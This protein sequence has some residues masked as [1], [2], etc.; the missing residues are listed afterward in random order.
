M[1]LSNSPERAWLSWTFKGLPG[2]GEAVALD[3]IGAQSWNVLDQDVMLPVAVIYNSAIEHNRRWMTAFT[4]AASV[5]LCP[6]GKTTMSPQLLEMQIADGAW[7]ITAATVAHVRTYRRFGIDRIIL[8]NQLIGKQNIAYIFDELSCNLGLDFYCLVDSIAA[9]EL[10][11]TAATHLQFGGRLQ[12]LLELGIAG[13]RT[14][15]RQ[16]DV[17]L[18]LAERIAK[19]PLLLLRGIEAFEGIVQETACDENTVRGLLERCA[20]LAEA[21]AAA[22]FFAGVPILS[23]G[24]SGFFDLACSIMSRAAISPNFDVV[25]RSGCYLVHD[26]RLYQELSRR[27]AAR[28][29]DMMPP[30]PGL[31]PA[32]ELWA[33]VHSMPEPGRA[34][35]SIGKRDTS[36]DAG[37]PRPI[38]WCR[39]RPDGPKAL[40]GHEVV[41]LDDQHAYL[42]I[43][44][45]SPLVVGDLVGFGISHPCTT[46]DRWPALY[47]VDDGLTVTGAVQTFF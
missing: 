19:S 18:Q 2:R 12:V 21:C 26:S 14:G 37:L 23:A 36:F 30:G 1:E 44:A 32:L 40:V 15:L 7:G 35:V 13:G 38:K 31:K 28:S 27:L 22:G 47:L 29:P 11:E 3:E 5:R 45:E 24:G 20:R 9:I 46:F 34:I 17:A 42:D 16:D 25:L 10:L 33:C 39:S 4:T 6:H 43:P 8:A 41:R